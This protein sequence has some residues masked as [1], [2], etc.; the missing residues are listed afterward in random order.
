MP[1][2]LPKPRAEMTTADWE[3]VDAVRY[4]TWYSGAG[5]IF[6]DEEGKTLVLKDTRSGKWTFPKGVPEM[7]DDEIPLHTAY[8]ET[9]EEIG[10]MPTDYTVLSKNALS[11]A[12]NRLYF[13]A[14]VDPE[15]KTKIRLDEE[16]TEAVWLSQQ[17][18]LKAWNN[19]NNGVKSYTRPSKRHYQQM[20]KMLFA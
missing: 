12:Y 1:T 8:R 7:E 2:V 13:L 19:L 9:M 10:L 17:D 16:N 15:A 18:L 3:A 5:F 6:L 4:K 20:Q 14:R 11:F